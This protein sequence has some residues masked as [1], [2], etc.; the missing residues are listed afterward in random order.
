M[1]A[2]TDGPKQDCT[3]GRTLTPVQA[4]QLLEAA[5]GHRLEAAIVLMLSLGLRRGE[6][7]GLR[8]VDVD[9]ERRVLTISQ[10]LKKIGT[11]VVLGDVKT[12]RS[13]R[14]V[15]LPVEVVDVHA[16]HELRQRE[17]RVASGSD[18]HESGLVF[19]STLGGRLDPSNFRRAFDG[20]CV[21]AGLAGWHPHELRHSAASI[22]LAEGVPLEVVSRV[23]GHASIRVTSDVYAHLL[24]PQREQAAAAMSSALWGDGT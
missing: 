22:M 13:R 8:W 24:E 17:E 19:T 12:E 1:F 23:L 15:N 16:Q 7:L 20:V 14:R 4:R 11:S 5:K 3:E 9:R 6:T 21:R 2:L 18:W 10:S